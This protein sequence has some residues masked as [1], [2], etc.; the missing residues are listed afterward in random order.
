MGI[1]GELPP[2]QMW[3]KLN[4]ELKAWKEADP[5]TPVVPAFVPFGGHARSFC[6]AFLPAVAAV[7]LTKYRRFEEV[8]L[9]VA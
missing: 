7:K 2:N 8:A 5:S 6:S 4:S 9:T 1:L 3:E